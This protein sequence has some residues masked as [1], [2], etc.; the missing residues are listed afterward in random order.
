MAV[1]V[2]LSGERAWYK[3]DR[4]SPSCP[5]FVDAIPR[6]REAVSRPPFRRG[7]R[8]FRRGRCR[9]RLRRQY[10]LIG[11]LGEP[12]RLVLRI[13]EFIADPLAG[14]PPRLNGG[15]HASGGFA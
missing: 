13:H 1:R 5:V 10:R 11:A 6:G 15:G 7:P 12:E 3:K 9:V 14:A 8:S 2:R 4:T